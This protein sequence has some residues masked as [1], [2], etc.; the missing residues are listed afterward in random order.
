VLS[1]DPRLSHLRSTRAEA[2]LEK[3]LQSHFNR[4]MKLQILMEAA[5][6]RE[7]PARQQQRERDERQQ[8]AVAE[9]EQD[10]GVRALQAAFDA[11]I[12]SGSIKPLD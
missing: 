10:E 6:D 12:V 3:A 7:T 8:A 2:A 4:P 11:R 9:I 5:P 1:L